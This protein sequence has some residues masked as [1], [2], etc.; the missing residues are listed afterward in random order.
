MSYRIVPI[1]ITT[2]LLSFSCL[3]QTPG[4]RAKTAASALRNG[5]LVVRLVSNQRKT[6]A[7]REMLANPELKDKEKN[8]IETLLR[9]T[10]S[11]TREKNGL[12]MKIFKAEFKICPVFFMYDSDSRRLLQKET[13][14]F[15]L[16]DN[17]ET[18]PSITLANIPYLVLKF[19]YTDESTTSRAEAMIFMDDQLQDLEAP[20]PYAFPLSNAGL[21]L[22]HLTSGNLAFE[23][24]FRKRVAKL[25][26]RLAKAIGAL[27]E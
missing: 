15:F 13:G 2:I 25:N 26:K 19:A 9:E 10:E 12:I 8:R 22:T 5:A 3:A 4:D 6:E 18:D 21:A 20:F 23:K 7:F 17:L 1:V 11:E 16:N 14:G 24:H 27:L